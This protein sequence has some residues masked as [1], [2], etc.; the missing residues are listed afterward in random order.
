MLQSISSW[1]GQTIPGPSPRLHGCW[2][3]VTVGMRGAM[4]ILYQELLS[5]FTFNVL[6][7][8]PQSCAAAEHP[9][10]GSPITV[11]IVRPHPNVVV[12]LA[13]IPPGITHCIPNGDEPASQS[14]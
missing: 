7:G 12:H 9:R 2:L 5:K 14:I 4:S 1:T 8:F 11:M 13:A 10:A 6:E 3:T